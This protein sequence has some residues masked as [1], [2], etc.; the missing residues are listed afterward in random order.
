MINPKCLT[1]RVLNV[2]YNINLDSHHSFH[3]NSKTA[4]IPDQLE[5]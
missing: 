4:N 2:G 5:I 1:D 3:I